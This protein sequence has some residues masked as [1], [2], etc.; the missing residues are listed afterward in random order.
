[1]AMAATC[2]AMVVPGAMPLTCSCLSLTA[3][4]LQSYFKLKH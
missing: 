1:M 4:T 2:K 3:T